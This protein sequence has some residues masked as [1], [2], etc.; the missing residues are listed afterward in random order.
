MNID[1]EYVK[2][3]YCCILYAIEYYTESEKILKTIKER[4]LIASELLVVIGH[5]VNQM[6]TNNFN[7][8]TY[9]IMPTNVSSWLKSID[10]LEYNIIQAKSKENLIELLG[11]LIKDFNEDNNNDDDFKLA[12]EL[13]DFLHS[14]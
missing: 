4:N 3:Y 5:K 1:V 13:L 7:V 12:I 8:N 9:A 14:I 11:N 2:R 10:K 6:L